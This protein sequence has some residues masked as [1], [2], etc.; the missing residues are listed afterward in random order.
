MLRVFLINE[1]WQ[2]KGFTKEN[3]EQLV[4]K[5][6]ENFRLDLMNRF[7]E[8]I[9]YISETERGRAF[10]KTLL[11]ENGV[12]FN[13]ELLR[14]EFGANF[15]LKLTEADAASALGCL[16]STVGKWSNEELLAFSTGRRQIVNSLERIVIWKEL[17]V[18]GSRILLAL[19]EAENE[20]WANNASGIF[21]AL[22]SPATGE[23]APTEASPEQKIPNLS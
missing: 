2:D 20:S 7:L 17:F 15:F 4:M 1:W 5:I 3:F 9:P 13:G 23:M 14:S 16:Q 22:F 12:F 21:A 11:G 10:A 8:H 18:G 6:P 19:A